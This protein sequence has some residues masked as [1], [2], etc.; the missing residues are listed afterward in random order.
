M[1]ASNSTAITAPVSAELEPPE[2]FAVN[3]TTS[4]N[5]VVRKIIEARAYAKHV[6]EWAD[7][8]LRRAER[9]EQCFLHAYGRQLEDWARAE[10]AKG[11]RKSVKLPAGTLGFRTDPP[12][13]DVMDEMKL[14]AWCRTSLPT[15]LRI[16]THIFKQH[17]K[18]HFTIT[19]ECPDGASISGG[20][21][22]FYVR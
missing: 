9:E 10:I 8:E 17:V 20:G 22:R 19:G 15:A 14:I 2:T 16:E 5:W 3:D 21:Q 7:G 18:D 13:L 4:A 11:R 6:K 1:K 12:K